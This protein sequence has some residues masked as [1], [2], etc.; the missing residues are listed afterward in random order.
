MNISEQ[1]KTATSQ[2]E[3]FQIVENYLN[4]IGENDSSE[5]WG[6]AAERL[7]NKNLELA[8]KRWFELGK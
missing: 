3:L 4:S 2:G 6:E 8:E 1:I 7:E 5:S